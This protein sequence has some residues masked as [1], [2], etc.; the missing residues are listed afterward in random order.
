MLV[1]FQSTF[2]AYPTCIS[3]NK[4]INKQTNVSVDGWM[5]RDMI[6][7]KLKFLP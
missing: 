6:E 5:E 2:K 3:V 4:Q 1:N 7:M